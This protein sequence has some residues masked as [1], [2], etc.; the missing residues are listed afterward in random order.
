[1]FEDFGSDGADL[2][3]HPART[4]PLYFRRPCKIATRFASAVPF[5]VLL[6][7][8]VAVPSYSGI[9]GVGVPCAAK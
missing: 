1:M 8:L 6:V 3:L 7:L 4:G 9:S 2:R 5:L